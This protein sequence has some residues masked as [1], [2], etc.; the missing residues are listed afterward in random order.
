MKTKLLIGLASGIL[1]NAC[2]T[3]PDT[4]PFSEV[5]DT[6][7]NTSLA[8]QSDT[9]TI[10]NTQNQTESQ[11]QSETDT[12]N[13]TLTNTITQTATDTITQTET[14]TQ[15]QTQS[16][17][18]TQTQTDV[19]INTTLLLDE[20]NLLACD[21]QNLF[22]YQYSPNNG[23]ALNS[24]NEVGASFTWS[25]TSET[26]NQLTI[27]IRY[28]HATATGRS[29]TVTLDQNAQTADFVS[30]NTWDN[31]QIQTIVFNETLSAGNH[32][33]TISA[34]NATGLANIDEV[35]IEA[36]GELIDVLMPPC[37]QPEYAYCL[38]EPQ[39]GSE[40]S[41]INANNALGW[42][43]AEGSLNAG[44]DLV[45]W[46]TLNNADQIYRA[47]KINDNLW[48]FY[49]SH[50]DLPIAVRDE[51]L[52]GGIQLEQQNNS[53]GFYVQRD[54]QNQPFKI[55]AAQS[56]LTVSVESADQ[57]SPVIQTRDDQTSQG[58]WF[59]NPTENTCTTGQP[60]L[61]ETNIEINTPVPELISKDKTVIEPF[62][63]QC[64]DQ[65]QNGLSYHIQLAQG[66]PAFDTPSAAN[67]A[68]AQMGIWNFSGG[69]HQIFLLE[70]VDDFDWIIKPEHSD[71][72][73]NFAN[74]QSSVNANLELSTEPAHFDLIQN[75]AGGPFRL[76]AKGTNL[77]VTAS[78]TSSGDVL[79][80][81][82]FA[83]E[84]TQR[85]F[86]NPVYSDCNTT[87][88][89]K[90][91]PVVDDNDDDDVNVPD[92]SG[93]TLAFPGAQGLGRFAVGG[94]FGEV[95]HV[96]NLNDSGAGSLR[97][98]ISQPNRIVVF[99]VSGVIKISERLVFKQNQTIACQTA[100]GGGITI[101][102]NGTSMSGAHNLIIRYCRIRMGRIGTSGKDTLAA[103]N[104]HDMMLDHMSLSWGR[105][106]NFDLNTSSGATLYN[107]SLQDSIVAQGLQ[108]HST[109]G[110]LANT[111]TSVIRNLWIDNNSRNPK[112]RGT[113]QWVNNVV[114]NWVASGY[115]LGDTT[116]RSDGYMVGNYYISGPEK[117]SSTLGSPGPAYNMYA[118]DNWYDSN[119]DG[120][121]NGR[122]LGK[123]D[124]GSVT[125]H[126][127]TPS[128]EFPD[129]TILSAQQAFDYVIANA[130]ASKWRDEPD[131]YVINEVLS[132]GTT[133]KTISNETELGLTNNVG[134]IPTGTLPTDSDNDGMADSWEL[135][136]GLN[137]NNP[138]DA[139]TDID[140]DGWVNIEEYI[141]SLV[142]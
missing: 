127:D 19:E 54:H 122:L 8:T 99:D 120:V 78:G 72:Y 94:R 131:Q 11:T 63:H 39:S 139:M 36:D 31:W 80:L 13:E 109:G 20:R 73:L 128:I 38:D 44:A 141:N 46:E 142:K 81:K 90:N 114:Y 97:D 137:P 110:L 100:P 45:I 135:A 119:R 117:G 91:M 64:I 105:D 83:D 12:Q 42:G 15:T 6:Q 61:I 62:A 93:K 17:T 89:N 37:A 138:A 24:A 74:G 60:Q 87:G 22:E 103:A 107:I 66:G 102:G 77:S 85:W 23:V 76:I 125:W 133:G 136:N 3:T 123:G 134:V 115:I 140:G 70:M 130:G 32:D 113:L 84:Q 49:P 52:V 98:A 14:E 95:V 108:T 116:G 56:G 121:Q 65:P 129:V 41:I 5:N 112:A 59:F 124:Y 25:F 35:V 75:A 27:K 9:N 10:T 106:A 1:L 88:E 21:Y 33:L 111:G 79:S 101:Y 30:T 2:D 68:G 86:L 29:A 40:Y 4:T 132:W 126:E 51:L 16:Q 28:A 50:S 26:I 43:I 67:V 58:R 82:T 53:V 57:G 34:L 118:K 96:T 47:E 104:G 92:P 48:Q 7:T 71:L 69:K 18:N 55:V